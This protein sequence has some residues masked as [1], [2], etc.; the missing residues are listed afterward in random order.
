MIRALLLTVGF[1]VSASAR[2]VDVYLLG[3]QSNM[4]GIAKL[5]DLPQHQLTPA[6][7]V[8]FWNGKEFEPLIPGETKSSQRAGEF[9]PELSF[10]H[11]IPTPGRPVFLV[12]YS[13]SGMPLDAGWNADKWLGGAQPGRVNFF[14]G[15]HRADP[16]RGRLYS[17]MITRFGEAIGAL[18]QHGDTPVIR[19]FLWMQGEQDA[20]NAISAERYPANLKLLRHRLSEDLRVADLPMAFGQVLPYNPPLPR[21]TFRDLIRRQMAACD[22]DSGSPLAIAHCRMVST[23]GFPIGTD[24]VHYIAKGQLLLGAALGKGVGEAMRAR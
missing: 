20:K 9:G 5:A 3:G 4:Q 7:G 12:K 19:G 13:A 11:A 10:A 22:M 17:A 24:T 23:D 14:P 18:Y 16:N 15:T 8:L 1:I 2:E 21:F 6:P